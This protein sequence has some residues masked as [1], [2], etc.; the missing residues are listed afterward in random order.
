[1]SAPE[2]S[3]A[4]LPPR[5]AALQRFMLAPVIFATLLMLAAVG[6]FVASMVGGSAR[7]DRVELRLEGPCAAAALP[8]VQARIDAV[9]LGDPLLE[10][11][12]GA[13][14]LQATL[15]GLQDDHAAIPAL[16]SRRGAFEV[17]GPGGPITRPDDVLAAQVRLDESGAA[18][19]WVDLRPEAVEAVEAAREADPE[20]E[21]QLVIDGA[22]TVP[23]PNSV[24]VVEGGLRVL[25]DM[26]DPRQRMRIATDHA[27]ALEHGP[28]PCALTAA[29]VR[30]LQPGG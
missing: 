10:L 1:M 29:G 12:D 15:P 28:L 16:L 25:P 17:V 14:A 11:K 26:Q 30:V 22:P 24:A 9:G 6:L 7:G 27:I 4:A 18:Y 8:L 19:T 23:R 3:G 13:L 21:L 5:P 2:P 20:G